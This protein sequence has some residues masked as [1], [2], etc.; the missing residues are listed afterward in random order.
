M[1][2]NASLTEETYTRIRSDLIAC[3][4]IPGER[5]K[6]NE[7]SDQLSVSLGAVREA[8]SRLAAEG[9]V[10]FER[11]KGFS[12]APVSVEDLRHLYEATF[13]LEGICLRRSIALGDIEWEARVVAAYH[14][15]KRTPPR[16]P[17]HP[18]RISP[19]ASLAY[20]RFREAL[21]SACGNPR[22]LR[23]RDSVLAQN[24]RYRQIC[25]VLGPTTPDLAAG[26]DQLVQAAIDR[27]AERAVTVLGDRLRAN[28]DVMAERL[29]RT[30]LSHVDGREVRQQATNTAADNVVRPSAPVRR[31]RS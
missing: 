7:L 23:L 25:L 2:Q 22:L 24:E 5:L 17:D 20:G 13:E 1:N 10:T 3:N 14:R 6:T 26:Y 11:Q 28:H 15:L 12:A 18:V 27:D 16:S 8:L 21:V 30:G 19:A 31:R 4:F 9:F 29:A